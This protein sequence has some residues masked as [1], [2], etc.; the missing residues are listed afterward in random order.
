MPWYMISTL[1]IFGLL[2]I[3]SSS[4]PLSLPSPFRVV[5]FY[6]KENPPYNVPLVYDHKNKG[7]IHNFISHK[8]FRE[9]REEEYKQIFFE[10]TSS[11]LLDLITNDKLS[12]YG[13]S[14]SDVV[15]ISGITVQHVKP[16]RAKAYAVDKIITSPGSA[17]IVRN[18]DALLLL[19]LFTGMSEC[20]SIIYFATLAAI[21]VG[22]FV[23]LLEH[24]GNE[25]FPNTFGK[26][27]WIGFWFCYVTMTTVGYGDKT[28]KYWATR[29]LATMW[30]V[31][32]VMTVAMVTTT[33]MSNAGNMVKLK[34]QDVAVLNAT[35]EERNVEQLLGAKG[36]RYDNYIEILKAVK[37]GYVKAALVD[38]NVAAYY[39]NKFSEAP[40][41]SSNSTLK[42]IH[43]LVKSLKAQQKIDKKVPVKMY[44]F[45]G[46]NLGDESGTKTNCSSCCVCKSLNS[47]LD[48]EEAKNGEEA[49]LSQMVTLYDI[50][51]EVTPYYVRSVTDIFDQTDRGLLLFMTIIVVLLITAGII[52][53]VYNVF[54]NKLTARQNAYV[55]NVTEKEYKA[56]LKKLLHQKVQRFLES[57]VED[58]A[59]EMLLQEQQVSAPSELLK[60]YKMDL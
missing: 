29:A 33:V 14:Q 30:M 19:K 24:R 38:Q 22:A 46:E 27:L 55:F 31:F 21:I 26:G 1:C 60:L 32:A 4:P 50:S 5:H 34:N 18:S 57:A 51:L 41:D 11:V 47:Q 23:W 28:P 53:E 2:K 35:F 44:M 6:M 39:F 16:K 8:N 59:E 15:F 40:S 42:E 20:F 37:Y 43:L 36:R 17:V 10:T 54:I 45:Y 25:D 3:S 49:F 12:N 13:I 58:I 48:H 56:R 7:I 9:K 52:V